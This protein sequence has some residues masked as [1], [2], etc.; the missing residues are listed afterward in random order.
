L[1]RV[2]FESRIASDLAEATRARA[3]L[4]E[5]L[6][7]ALS[8]EER[9]AIPEV[10][11]AFGE[12]VTN[13]V[14]HAYGPGAQG[15]IDIAVSVEEGWLEIVVRDYGRL[16]DPHAYHPP[17]LREPHEGG[18]GIHLVRQ[19]MDDLAIGSA[20]GG[21]NRCAVRR[22]LTGRSARSGALTRGE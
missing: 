3:W 16:M 15:P 21:G 19:L 8:P 14:R 17:D 13:A 12:L 22:R 7:Q 11:L 10:L 1:P 18:Y 20:E 5:R 4:R 2:T 6:L 9:D